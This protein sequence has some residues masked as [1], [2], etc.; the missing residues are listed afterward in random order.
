[1]LTLLVV[2]LVPRLVALLALWVAAAWFQTPAGVGHADPALRD[3]VARDARGNPLFLQELAR[4][5]RDPS[6]PLPETLLAAIQLEVDTL[7]PA[8]RA[9]IDGA[10]VAGDPFDPE[11]APA[12]AALDPA[13][14]LAPLD[15]LLAPDPVR[16]GHHAPA[17]WG[18]PTH[19]AGGGGG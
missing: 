18:A 4:A 17:G 16:P 1:M 6:G 13:E 9:L 5:A 8:S 15:R 3:R 11:L 7:P 14:A 19:A 12:A 10:A 2:S